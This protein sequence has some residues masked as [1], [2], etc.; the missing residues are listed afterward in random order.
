M[1]RTADTRAGATARPGARDVA[2]LYI[3]LLKKALLGETALE[4]EAA[5]FMA[6]DALAAGGDFDEGVAYDL[7]NG[8]PERY[9]AVEATRRDGSHKVRNVG[10]SYT[11]VGRQRLDN[12]DHCVAAAIEDGVEGDLIECGVWRGGATILMRG[13]LAAYGIDDRTVWVADSFMGLPK[14]DHPNDYADLSA[15]KRPQL[16]V[17]L[18]R[19]KQNFA[20]FD[21]LDDRVRFV[22]GWFNETLHELPVESLCV[23]RLDGDLYE[24]TMTTLEA[25]YDRVSPGGFVIVDDYGATP[26]C[27]AAVDEFRAARGITDP[28]EEIDWTGAFWR[29]SGEAGT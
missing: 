25:L 22:P 19:V 23:L 24:S 5:Y 3:E 8:A 12:L 21:L 2:R 6:R 28:I 11:M 10:F 4:A 26:V 18:E 17:S 13:I 27:A 29:K 9:R 7:R 20:T 1:E 14:P 15:E 16:A